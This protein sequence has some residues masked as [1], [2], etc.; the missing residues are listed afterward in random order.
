LGRVVAQVADWAAKL[1]RTLARRQV[2]R[3]TERLRLPIVLRRYVGKLADAVKEAQVA[4]KTCASDDDEKR[5]TISA[6]ATGRKD[7]Q[8]G[9]PSLKDSVRYDIWKHDSRLMAVFDQWVSAYG[10]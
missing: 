1:L 9:S 6:P 3:R 8:D 7:Q 2:S 4:D 10:T 5:Q